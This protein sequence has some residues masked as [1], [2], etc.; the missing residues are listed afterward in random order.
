MSTPLWFDII[1]LHHRGTIAPTIAFLAGAH[2][3]ESDSDCLRGLLNCMLD[4]I[5][6]NYIARIYRC[7]DI[8]QPVATVM[9]SIYEGEESDKG[10][11]SARQG[12]VT[13]LLGD[14]L[15]CC[16]T[17]EQLFVY[18]HRELSLDISEKHYSY[19]DGKY[20]GFNREDLQIIEMAKQLRKC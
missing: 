19:K 16:K 8:N 6:K 4:N 10:L 17:L 7:P 9:Y 1:Q 13:I 15:T 5:P 12:R 11:R 3:V 20:R 2:S 18:L 14:D